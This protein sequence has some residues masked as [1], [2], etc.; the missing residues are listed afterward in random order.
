M[1]P[2]VLLMHGCADT[3]QAFQ[4]AGWVGSTTSAGGGTTPAGA[5][6]N[7][8]RATSPSHPNGAT[9]V[10]LL[11]YRN[12]Q[13]SLRDLA[14]VVPA[15]IDRVRAV[16]QLPNTPVAVIGHSLG[17]LLGRTYAQGLAHDEGTNPPTA[18]PYRSDLAGLYTI[19]SGHNG[20]NWVLALLFSILP[21]KIC[22]QVG[23]R[24]PSIC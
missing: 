7:L 16:T 18:V 21:S 8:R 5:P 17:G 9:D 19:A 15:A 22:P 13:T 23:D 12:A 14:C 4:H 6:W 20:A 24:R 10:F 11:D 1:P 2:P 3:W